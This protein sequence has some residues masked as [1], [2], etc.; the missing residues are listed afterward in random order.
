MTV[1]LGGE[2]DGTV[3]ANGSREEIEEVAETR[4]VH[5]ANYEGGSF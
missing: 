2:G 5:G 3:V 1:C 4:V